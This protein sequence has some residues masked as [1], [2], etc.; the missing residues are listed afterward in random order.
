MTVRRCGSAVETAVRNKVIQREPARIVGVRVDRTSFE[1]AVEIAGRFLRENKP[2]MIV[3]ADASSVA[4]AQNDREFLRIINSADLVTPDSIGILWAAKRLGMPIAER[5]SGV[6]LAWRL[7]GLCA[8]EGHPVFLL[9]AAPGVANEA[10]ENLR[11]RHSGL[12]IAGVRHGFFES[13]EEIVE[14]IR[15]SGARL[16]LVAM[17]I[18]K[19]EKWI[20]GNLDHLNVRLAIGV[21]GTFDVFAG[22]VRR[23]PQWMRNHGLEWAYRLGTSPRRIKKVAKL[24]K[25]VWLVMKYGTER[26]PLNER[27]G[28]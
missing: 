22:N 13:D 3:T 1:E 5:V 27:R 18:P 10:A 7:C 25:F 4:I 28:R 26:A 14:E 9:G 21:G 15:A 23:A 24:P 19:Q 12:I 2:R 16:L 6:D 11:R 8:E 17:G 20:A